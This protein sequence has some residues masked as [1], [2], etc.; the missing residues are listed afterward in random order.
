MIKKKIVALGL[1]TKK[2]QIECLSLFVYQLNI[3]EQPAFLF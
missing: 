3:I 2:F 1:I